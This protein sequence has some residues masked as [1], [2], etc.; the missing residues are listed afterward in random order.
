MR[1]TRMHIQS[2]SYD[3]GQEWITCGIHESN[4]DPPDVPVITGKTPKQYKKELL[5]DA[6]AG[7]AVATVNAVKPAIT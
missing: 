2:L 4:N 1:S 5:S 6:I 7:A 3:S